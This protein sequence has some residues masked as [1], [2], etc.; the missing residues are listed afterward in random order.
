M[1]LVAGPVNLATPTGVERVDVETAVEMAAA[2]KEA[3][4]ADIGVMVAAV[5]DW[6]VDKVA[7]DKIKKRGSA[8]PALLLTENPDILAT[9]AGSRERPK[10]LVGASRPK[11]TD[12]LKHAA[13]KR[14]RKGVDWI[15]ANDVSGDV[16][17]GERNQVHIVTDR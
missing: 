11:P 5:A 2:V 13:D 17:G 1:T 7:E 16:M 14:K 15:V 6:R 3:L 8:P 10:L 4:P 12:M 9:V